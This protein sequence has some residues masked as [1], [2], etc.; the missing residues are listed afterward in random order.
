M[1]IRSVEFWKSW[2]GSAGIEVS[3]FGRAR[4]LDCVRCDDN[5]ARYTRGRYY[6]SS[7][8]KDGYQ[9]ATIL[10]NGKWTTKGIH[11]LVAETFVPNPN[12]MPQVNHKDGSRTN[13]NACNLEWSTASYNNQYKEKFGKSQK[14]PAFAINLATLEVSWFQSQ[15]EASRVLGIGVGNINVV[16]KGKGKQASGYWFVEDN[17]RTVENTKNRLHGIVKM[18]IW[19]KQEED[20]KTTNKLLD[21]VAKC[22][23]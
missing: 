1:I 22:S 10:M 19:A 7:F 3:S 8:N 11:R 9:Q 6:K 16:I 23:S 17:D 13:N 15:T 2:P 21:F 18:G 4:S 14:S 20:T 5:G 12:H